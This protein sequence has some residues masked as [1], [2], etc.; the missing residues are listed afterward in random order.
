MTVV[1]DASALLAY[2]HDEPGGQVIEEVLVEAVMS[3][4]NWAEVVQKSVAADVNVDGMREDLEAL[5]LKI[6]IFTPED[7]EIAGRLWLQTKQAGL[8][9]G[10]RACLSLGLK[11]NV[12]VLTCDRIWAT[13]PLILD[14]QVI[15]P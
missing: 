11:L 4:V 13:L 8:S 10:D 12:S 9:L 7:G 15:R 3:S 1:L 6:A 14:V 5:G 2:L